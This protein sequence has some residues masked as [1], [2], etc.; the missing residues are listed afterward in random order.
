MGSDLQYYC[1]VPLQP[2]GPIRR[3]RLDK[4]PISEPGVK[5]ERIAGLTRSDDRGWRG[6]L[7][8]SLA[9]PGMVVVLIAALARVAARREST[10]VRPESR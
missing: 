7:D 10:K 3:V 6:W 1:G 4:L 2:I 5:V 8:C 9:S